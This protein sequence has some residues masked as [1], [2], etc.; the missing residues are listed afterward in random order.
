MA[1]TDWHRTL[2]NWLIDMLKLFFTGVPRVYVSGNLL[3][4]YEPGN[5]RRHVSPDVFVV[6]GV[7][8]YLRPNYLVWEEKKGPE[9]VVE[10]TSS[11]T[12]AE[13]TR[14]KLRLYQDVLKVR[15]YFLFD[16]N[17][18][19]LSPPLEGYRLRGGVYHPIRAAQGRLP[20]QVLGLHLEAVGNLLR[21]W[22]PQTQGWLLTP[23]EAR[24]E[25]EQ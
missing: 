20:S 10:L 16:P 3:V 21:L 12:R 11:S 1:E 5:R 22:D 19:Y 4:F 15:E 14:T 8:N 24:A 9:V 13:D 25:A 18:D 7:E 6:R 23:P 17:G 2:M